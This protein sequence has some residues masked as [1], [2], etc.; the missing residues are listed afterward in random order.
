MLAT[1][2][3]MDEL[4]PADKLRYFMGIGDPA[5][6]VDVIARGVD[7]FDCVLP[8]RLARTGT[9]FY[10]GGRLNLRNAR[11]AADLRPLDADATATAAG[12]SR[13][14]PASPGEPEGDAR[15]RSC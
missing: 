12:R 15:R 7:V 14:L 11:F 4:L 10:R 6:I 8:T 5:G 3:L 2:E 1:V 13:A 9:A